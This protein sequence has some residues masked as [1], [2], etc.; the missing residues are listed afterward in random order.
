MAIPVIPEFYQG[1][2]KETLPKFKETN[3]DKFD[4]ILVDGAH[5]FG[6][7]S[8]DLENVVDLVAKNGVIV[9]DD[10]SPTPDFLDNSM[11]P[12]WNEFK[13]RHF[14]EFKWHID[15]FGK[16]TAWAKKL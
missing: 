14:N 10:I 6:T 13:K 16:G 7:A 5:D 11:L 1:D 9:F 15:T 4:W 12:V 2:S 8:L 3:T